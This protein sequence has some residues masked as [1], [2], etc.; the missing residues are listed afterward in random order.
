MFL[1]G[2]YSYC[3]LYKTKFWVQ[4]ISDTQQMEDHKKERL[5]GRKGKLEKERK[6]GRAAFTQVQSYA[7]PWDSVLADHAS[8][9]WAGPA[10]STVNCRNQEEEAKSQKP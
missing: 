4:N 2:K 10:K 5:E 1:G 7:G 8:G 3:F 9:Y 6:E